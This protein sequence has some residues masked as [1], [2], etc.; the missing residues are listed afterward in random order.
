MCRC[1][2]KRP[3]ITGLTTMAA[4]V[5]RVH[6]SLLIY[7]NTCHSVHESQQVYVFM[8]S[9]WPPSPLLSRLSSDQTSC[10]RRRGD[11]PKRRNCIA[12]NNTVQ[13]EF[14]Y[15]EK[16]LLVFCHIVEIN[17]GSIRK[18]VNSRQTVDRYRFPRRPPPLEIV[19][20]LRSS[21]YLPLTPSLLYSIFYFF[22]TVLRLSPRLRFRE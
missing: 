3:E 2:K 6:Q 15:S 13:N 14:S 18:P 4:R 19:A 8:R 1:S 11:P 16:A 10:C 21:T 12:Y 5:V 7:W 22:P 17:Y 20:F 9:R